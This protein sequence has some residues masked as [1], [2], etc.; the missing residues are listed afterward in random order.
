MRAHHV[1]AVILVLSIGLA[2]KQFFFP[3]KKAEADIRAA[4]NSGMDVRQMYVNHPN[5]K[6]L[7][8]QTMLDKTSSSTMSDRNKFLTSFRHKHSVGWR[9][10]DRYG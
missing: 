10:R 8:V 5:I 2:A 4:S 9:G 6:N 1:I 3:A 7:P